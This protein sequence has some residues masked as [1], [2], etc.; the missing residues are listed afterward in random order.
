MRGNPWRSEN[1]DGAHPQ[2]VTI[3][4]GCFR[5]FAEAF[6]CAK[7]RGRQ[8]DLCVDTLSSFTPNLLIIEDGRKRLCLAAQITP[9]GLARCASVALDTRTSPVLQPSSS[10]VAPPGESDAFVADAQIPSAEPQLVV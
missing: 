9:R 8:P 2:Q 7:R 10:A 3:L 1:N 6:A 5:C 4:L